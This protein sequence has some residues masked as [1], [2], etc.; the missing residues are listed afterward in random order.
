MHGMPNS[1]AAERPFFHLSWIRCLLDTLWIVHLH[2]S[3]GM[4]TQAADS[5]NC[6]IVSNWSL[7]RSRSV[8]GSCEAVCLHWLAPRPR[9]RSVSKVCDIH[10]HTLIHY[11]TF[12]IPWAYVDQLDPS[13]CAKNVEVREKG[14]LAQ[15]NYWPVRISGG[16]VK[17][18][19]SPV[20]A[21]S[22][23]YSIPLCKLE[24]LCF[25]DVGTPK[26]NYHNRIS[27]IATFGVLFLQEWRNQVTEHME[28]VGRSRCIPI[29]AHYAL[30][31]KPCEYLSK[32]K[33][34]VPHL[35]SSL[36][37]QTSQRHY[38][39]RIFGNGTLSSLVS[40]AVTKLPNYQEL[41]SGSCTR[42]TEESRQG[43][44]SKIELS[45]IRPTGLLSIDI[46]V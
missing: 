4:R 2:I 15:R 12:M 41:S 21:Q 5:L 31:L 32:L 46:P 35:P 17:A 43:R 20:W 10:W 22:W 13:T 14:C 44:V 40:K 28:E 30:R 25:T 8:L 34:Q 39:F 42:K 19:R 7:A 33:D 23:F 29:H 27:K 3:H 6:S 1:E 24:P 26:Q 45:L 18:H 36:Q 9:G 16:F 11:D 38:S 37:A